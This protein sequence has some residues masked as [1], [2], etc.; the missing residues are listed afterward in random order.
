MEKVRRLSVGNTS[1]PP[2]TN[3]MVNGSVEFGDPLKSN[4]TLKSNGLVRSNGLS[5][6]HPTITVN[7]TSNSGI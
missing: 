6:P 1:S 2:D 4:D 3:G 5:E 7:G